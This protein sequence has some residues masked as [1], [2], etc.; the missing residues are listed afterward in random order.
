MSDQ[1]QR[2]EAQR[3]CT[4]FDRHGHLAFEEGHAADFHLRGCASCRARH[5]N[6]RAAFDTLAAATPKVSDALKA[7][8][9]AAAAT[10]VQER[11]SVVAPKAR[12]DR[13]ALWAGLWTRFADPAL[14]TAGLAAVVAIFALGFQRIER[15]SA[16]RARPPAP[17]AADADLTGALHSMKQILVEHRQ[18][19]E[20]HE[21]A[22][23]AMLERVRRRQPAAVRVLPARQD[24]LNVS[25]FAERPWP[26]R[27]ILVGT[28][29]GD[30]CDPSQLKSP[31]EGRWER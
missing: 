7:R 14:A 31:C 26:G 24:F 18:E 30:W 19:V 27:R 28:S 1:Q 29:G 13:P 20:R 12:A 3:P 17:A 9:L 22:V 25:T 15:A 16:E 4:W 5:A 8:V 21:E 11:A 10:G 6:L 23:D 2:N